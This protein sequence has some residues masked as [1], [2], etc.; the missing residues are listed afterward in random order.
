MN[1]HQFN[2]KILDYYISRSTSSFIT[3][4]IDRSDLEKIIPIKKIDSFD[5]LKNC[6]NYLL[7]EIENIPQYFGLIAVQ[8]FA[9]SQ[10]H[11]D[12]YNAADAYQVR[13]KETLG[14]EPEFNLQNLFRGS[15]PEI[16]VQEEIWHRAKEFFHKTFGLYLD[17]P[18]RTRN[19]GRFVQYPKSQVLLTLEDLKPF[20]QF[21]LEEFKVGEDI[22]F[23]YFER[24]LQS[25][26]GNIR[27]PIRI[28]TFFEDETKCRNCTRQ[29]YDYFNRWQGEVYFGSNSIRTLAKTQ[30][31]ETG[32]SSSRLLLIFEK[33]SPK[34]F[35]INEEQNIVSEIDA[36]SLF[37]KHVLHPHEGLILFNEIDYENEFISSRFIYKSSINYILVNPQI[38]PEEY[39]SLER[40]NSEKTVIASNILLYKY[41]ADDLHTPIILSKYLQAKNPVSLFGGIKLSRK[42]EYLVGFGPSIH[43]TS[44]HTVL[45]DHNR[46]DYDPMRATV[47]N[48]KVRVDNFKDVE[49][50]IIEGNRLMAPIMSNNIGWNL[51]S[52]K[53]EEGFHVEGCYTSFESDNEIREWINLNLHKKKKKRYQESNVLFK[54]INQATI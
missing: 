1:Y 3:L 52:F 53:I 6:W 2:K 20:T 37:S 47:G 24:R 44:N 30:N 33:N 17:I 34:F 45:C 46:Y 31:S 8:C 50:R 16:A 19:T 51:R 28:Q 5:E 29:V 22:P 13:L 41:V 43:C 26:L 27:L 4:S 18:A 23:H 10:M 36:N 48:Y 15:D 40:L 21:F 39:R 54:A 14:L 35:V 12:E 11:S 7:K 32:V 38:K 25:S 42:K 9:A 49:F